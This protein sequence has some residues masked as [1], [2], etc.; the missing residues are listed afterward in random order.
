ME[1]S[2]LL[3][4]RIQP[5]EWPRLMYRSESTSSQTRRR[6]LWIGRVDGKPRS[7]FQS[8]TSKGAPKGTRIWKAAKER[9]VPEGA[10]DMISA[11]FMTRALMREG[12][13]S[14]TFPLVDKDRVWELT[15][16]RGQE[17][18]LEVPAGIF[19][20]VEVV[21]EPKPWP[22]EAIDEEKLEQ[23]EGVFGIQGT[24]HL[25]VDKKTGIAVRIQG[26]IPVKLGLTAKVDVELESHSGTPPEFAPLPAAKAAKKD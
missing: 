20:V 16:K 13:E 4:A 26:E 11:V 19:E 7:R 21:L 17:R 10:L 2:S 6:E 18:K 23:F 8:D 3:E 25:W 5:Q 12:K 22:D 14:L 24:I 15:L 1:L 9:A